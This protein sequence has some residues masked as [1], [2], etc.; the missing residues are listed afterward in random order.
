MIIA[1]E[2]AGILYDAQNCPGMHV[3]MSTSG[4]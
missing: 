3:I 1:S 2:I 4:I